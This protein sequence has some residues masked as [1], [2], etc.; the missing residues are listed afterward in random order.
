MSGLS[1]THHTLHEQ[2][3]KCFSLAAYRWEIH[4][5]ENITYRLVYKQQ[6]KYGTFSESVT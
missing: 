2:T 6:Q 3:N 5:L 4:R 1:E